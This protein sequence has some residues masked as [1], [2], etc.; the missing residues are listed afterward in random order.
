[1]TSE[2]DLRQ[3]GLFVA[4]DAKYSAHVAGSNSM[5]GGTR[6]LPGPPRPVDQELPWKCPQRIVRHATQI[7]TN[8][9]QHTALVIPMRHFPRRIV[10]FG[11]QLNY[12]PA[13]S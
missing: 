13:S 11:L 12:G 10:A 6:K 3:Q 9:T 2:R 7:A 5:L 8:C 1:M 4:V